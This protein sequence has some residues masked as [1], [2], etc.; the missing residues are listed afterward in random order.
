MKARHTLVTRQRIAPRPCVC[1]P[2]SSRVGLTD[3]E[4]LAAGT[5]LEAYK[6]DLHGKDGAQAVDGAVSHVDAMGEAA[7]EHQHQNVKGNQV[8]QEHVAPP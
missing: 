8:D 1:V 5:Y 4:E 3:R 6:G 7:C 2:T